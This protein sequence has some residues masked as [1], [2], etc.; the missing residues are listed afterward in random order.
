MSLQVE[1]AQARAVGLEDHLE[2]VKKEKEERR[3]LRQAGK[4][5]A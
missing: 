4:H 5:E 3:R 1:L 2:E